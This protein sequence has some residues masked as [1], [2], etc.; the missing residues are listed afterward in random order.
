[1]AIAPEEGSPFVETKGLA[2]ENVMNLLR[3]RI[4]SPVRVR[5]TAND[6]TDPREVDLVRGSIQV[7]DADILRAALTEHGRL[8][9][10]RRPGVNGVDFP[11]VVFLRTGD[12]LP[13]AVETIDEAGI[14]IRTPLGGDAA[15]GAVA[16][17]ARLVQAV[18]LVPTVRRDID[19]TRMERLLTVPRMQRA[20]PPT[21]LVRL[22]D[23]DYLRGRIT[24]LDA[25]RLT[26]ALADAVKDLPRETVARVIWLHPEDLA[27]PPAGGPPAA[28]GLVV[29]GVAAGGDRVT[30]DAASIDG[31]VIRGHHAAIGPATIDTEA[32]DRLL[33]GAAITAEARDLPYQRWKLKPASEPRALRGRAAPND[34]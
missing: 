15:G 4:G 24:A 11:A 13:C 34:G 23:G 3:G 5:V 31:T 27:A 9:P 8:A 33:F 22:M 12:A 28:A 18:E 25:R 26:L 2:I 7:N 6:G 32:V 19:R 16:V 1:M 30:V 14:R 10:G 20:H 29:Q 21:H 17:P